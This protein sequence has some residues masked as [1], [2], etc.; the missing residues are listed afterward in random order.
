MKINKYHRNSLGLFWGYCWWWRTICKEHTEEC[1]TCQKRSLLE[2][3]DKKSDCWWDCKLIQPLW[4]SVWQ[5]LRKL[6]I[7][8]PEDPDIPL[9]GI[10]P[11]YA[12]TYNKDT[13][14]TMFI[15]ALF[16]IARSWK[17]PRCP[18]TDEL[19]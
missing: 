2:C 17:E 15:A 4:K 12:P 13:C 11:K 7:V 10:Y 3:S 19:I 5:F 8:F 9:L 6:D 1:L 14:S 18:S 16:L